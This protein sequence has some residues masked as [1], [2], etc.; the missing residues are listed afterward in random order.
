MTDREDRLNADSAPDFEI[1]KNFLPVQKRGF[2]EEILCISRDLLGLD[3]A[4]MI[5]AAAPERGPMIADHPTDF[6]RHAHLT[7]RGGGRFG[8]ENHG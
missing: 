6:R 3:V 5:D 7:R 4:Q 1:A 8:G 2:D